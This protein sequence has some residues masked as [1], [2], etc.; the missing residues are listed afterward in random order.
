MAE[1][2]KCPFS[3]NKRAAVVRGRAVN[4]QTARRALST[5]DIRGATWLAAVSEKFKFDMSEPSDASGIQSFPTGDDLNAFQP[6]S[7]RP[8]TSFTF[9]MVGASP[10]GTG[11][12]F[13]K[14]RR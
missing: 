13:Y 11:R 12:S 5:V 7:P 1:N 2:T 3:R 4:R 10:A 6:E 8:S 14:I 9:G